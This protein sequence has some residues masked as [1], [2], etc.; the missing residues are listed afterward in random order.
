MKSSVDPGGW[1][2][3]YQDP[4]P[5]CR[6]AHISINANKLHNGPAQKHFGN[7][8]QKYQSWKNMQQP[9]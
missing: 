9:K 4:F 2:M 5:V 7:C 6:L 8:I 3:Q 1:Y